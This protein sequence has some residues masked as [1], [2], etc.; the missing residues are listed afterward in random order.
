MSARKASRASV[1]H[2]SSRDRNAFLSTSIFPGRIHSFLVEH[3]DSGAEE[4]EVD[5]ENLCLEFEK[6]KPYLVERWKAKA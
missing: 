5:T 2:R 3:Q 6:Q 4:M 1:S